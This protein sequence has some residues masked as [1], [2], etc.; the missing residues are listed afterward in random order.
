MN[1]YLASTQAHKCTKYSD[2]LCVLEFNFDPAIL[3]KKSAGLKYHIVTDKI[4]NLLQFLNRRLQ[5]IVHIGLNNKEL[6]ALSIIMTE[7]GRIPLV[8]LGEALLISN[9]WDGLELIFPMT[10][11]LTVR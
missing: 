9:I 6:D 3:N 1:E 10:R 5:T 4:A 2:R 11:Q 7:R 8:P